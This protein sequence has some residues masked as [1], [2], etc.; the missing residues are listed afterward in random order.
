MKILLVE[1]DTEISD[2]LRNFLISENFE[3]TAAFDGESACGEFFADEYSLV[4]L[5]LMIPKK[6]GMEVMRSIREKSTVPIIIL[7]AKDT[8]SDK[9]L[10]LGLG[11]DD[12]ITKPFSVTEVLARIKANIRRTTQYAA[13]NAREETVLKRGA[14]SLDINDYSVLK[15]G[16]RKELTAKEFEILKLLMQNPKKVYTKEQIYSHVWNDAYFGDENAVNVHISRLRNKIEDNPRDPR[17]VVTV[18]G[19]GYRLGDVE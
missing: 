3:V 11:A 8:D 12:Y 9:T 4:L 15:K 14:L 19:I 18:W 2:M 10:G 1:D 17:I 5:D 6:S 13:G 7:S 16:E